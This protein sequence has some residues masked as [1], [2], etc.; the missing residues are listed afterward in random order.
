MIQELATAIKNKHVILFVGSGVPKN[1]GLPV[2]S[3]LMNQ[4]AINLGYDPKQ[5]KAW[6]NSDFLIMA[7]YY[8]HH[9][10]TL[11]ALRSW[12]DRVVAS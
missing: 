8:F 3:E 5:F 4:M 1:L 10:G 12:M 7:E 2:Y 11:G 9:K 6:G